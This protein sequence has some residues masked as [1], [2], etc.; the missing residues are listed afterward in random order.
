MSQNLIKIQDVIKTYY[1]GE[2]KLD[3]LKS[4]CLDINDG[5][6]VSIM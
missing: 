5:E 3:V 4:V 1:L 6:F 2:E